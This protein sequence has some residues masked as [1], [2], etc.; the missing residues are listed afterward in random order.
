MQADIAERTEAFDKAH[1]DRT[2]LND[3]EVAELEALEKMQ[4]DVAEL[5][6]QL[7]QMNAGRCES[8]R[9]DEAEVAV[10]DVRPCG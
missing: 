4:L 3:D 1:P 9:Y 8:V 2:K 5:I 10:P 7:T 6:K